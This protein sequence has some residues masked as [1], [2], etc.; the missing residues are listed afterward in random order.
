MI[1]DVKTKYEDK[2]ILHLTP[3]LLNIYRGGEEFS[4]LTNITLNKL[5]IAYKRLSHGLCMQWFVLYPYKLQK[6]RIQ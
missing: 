6:N 5:S 4:S 2:Y 1:S 3:Y